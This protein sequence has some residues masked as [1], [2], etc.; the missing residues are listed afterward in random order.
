[1]H[2]H[3]D[4]FT[5]SLN[6]YNLTKVAEQKTQNGANSNN[7]PC[8]PLEISTYWHSLGWVMVLRIWK[9]PK[10]L[11]ELGVRGSPL[12]PQTSCGRAEAK[13]VKAPI[14][15]SFKGNISESQVFQ[16]SLKKHRISLTD[17]PHIKPV[18]VAP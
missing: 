6:I 7:S 8:F 16:D 9:R 2:T 4:F 3:T 18:F 1:M 11:M 13:K 15:A 14:S 10:I 12:L 5:Y 17:Q